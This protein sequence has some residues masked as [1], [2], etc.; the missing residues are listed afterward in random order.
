MVDEKQS[1]R[2][3]LTELEQIYTSDEKQDEISSRIAHITIDDC[4]EKNY[5]DDHAALD[6]LIE[7]INKLT[8]MEK[9]KDM[10]E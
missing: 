4:K 7:R 5:D 1:W 6:K 2:N 9:R 3:I 10:D 8:P